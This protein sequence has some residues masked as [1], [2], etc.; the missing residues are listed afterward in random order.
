MTGNRKP[1][2][3]ADA[4]AAIV[5]TA[6]KVRELLFDPEGKPH[7]HK[8]YAARLMWST[9]LRPVNAVGETGFHFVWRDGLVV[10]DPDEAAIAIRYA[11]G[12]DPTSHE[13][14][15]NV[16]AIM[17]KATDG[18]ADPALRDYHCGWLLLGAPPP[19]RGPKK[20][21]WRDW[22]IQGWLIPPLLQKGFHA[23]RNEATK[24]ADKDAQ[25]ACSLVSKALNSIGIK[26]SEKGVEAVWGARPSS[27]KAE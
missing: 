25:S 17:L 8:K 23:T 6:N 26:L 4:A 5:E 1:P 19:R 13:V 10:Y 27:M 7:G 12:G 9:V 16:V 21:S 14:L 2:S 24:H 18:I 3:A 22:C 11:R 20:N 15:R